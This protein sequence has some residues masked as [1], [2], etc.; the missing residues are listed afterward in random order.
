MDSL[1]LKE[2]LLL[3][4]PQAPRLALRTHLELDWSLEGESLRKGDVVY[5]FSKKGVERWDFGLEPL[6]I[7]EG[8]IDVWKR[9]DNWWIRFWA[10][11]DTRPQ[12]GKYVGS[13]C[14]FLAKC[15]QEL[16]WPLLFFFH[17]T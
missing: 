3:N 5:R 15:T 1:F 13:R 7:C 16:R 8:G 10:D 17:K 11:E 6:I 14:R 9:G 2:V 4:P 12:G